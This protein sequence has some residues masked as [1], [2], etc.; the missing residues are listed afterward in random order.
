MKPSHFVAL[1]CLAI[2][3]IAL[4]QSKPPYLAPLSMNASRPSPRISSQSGL[5]FAN[6]VTYDTGGFQAEAVVAADLN[7]D[8]KPDLAIVNGCGADSACGSGA[9]AVLLNNG[10]G[11]FATAISYNSMGFLA[12]AVAVG[13]V[14]GDGKPD[15]VVSNACASGPVAG[16]CSTDGSVAVLLGNGDGTFQA[17]VAYDTGGFSASTVVLADVNGDGKVDLLVLNHCGSSSS[18]ADSLVAVLL[19]NGDGTFKTA[20]N[21]DAG[22]VSTSE[23]LAVGDVNCDGTPDLIVANLCQVSTCNNN[24]DES[25]SVSILLGNG[26]GTFSEKTNFSTNLAG[27]DGIAVGDVNGDGKPDIAVSSHCDGPRGQDCG[28]N[29]SVSI[30]LGNGDGTFQ[31]GTQLTTIGVI[32]GGVT[33]LDVNGDGNPDVLVNSVCAPSNGNCSSTTSAPASVELFLGNGDGTFQAAQYFGSLGYAYSLAPASATEDVDGDGRPDLIL[34]SLCSDI[35]CGTGAAEHSLVGVTINTTTFPNTAPT[36]TVLS[37]TPNPSGAGQS[38]TFTAAVSQSGSIAP[39][40]TVTLV[41]GSSTLGIFSLNSSGIA[42]ATIA[43]LPLGNHNITATYNGGA[44]SSSSTS[45][46]VVQVVSQQDFSLT[47]SSPSATIKPGQTA[48]YGVTV[49]ALAG[50]NQ[51]VTLS[52]SGAPAF[53]V[54]SVSPSSVT[55]NSSPSTSVNVTVTTTGSSAA[56]REPFGH[57]N[58]KPELW[59]AFCAMPIISLGGIWGSSRDRRRI[60][61]LFALVCLLSVGIG[62]SACSGGGSGNRAGGTPTGTYNLTVTGS[63]SSGSTNLTHAATLVLD[64]L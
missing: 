27:T 21:Y 31:T 13:D 7:G 38:V 58:S 33:I 2:P 18:C 25:G 43:T 51:T 49:A 9:V 57:A 32:T 24:G 42:T 35:S 56:A 16:V 47:P 44:S 36:T 60:L 20:V 1:F 64:V 55:F 62:M 28:P 50:F 5:S 48:T 15:L 17:A 39:K 8:S 3:S 40:G 22:A 11:T 29:G 6:A 53:S 45:A 61:Q 19:G 30:F 41:D 63:A 46:A 34:T 23:A 12:S 54:C 26:D 10:N 4:G 59:L 14:N 52:C 37:S